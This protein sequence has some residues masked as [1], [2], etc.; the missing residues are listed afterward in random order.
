MLEKG[1]LQLHSKTVEDI[2]CVK[3]QKNKNIY[4]YFQNSDLFENT[5][6]T[7][8]YFHICFNHS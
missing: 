4:S 1:H 3:L 6:F 2:I 8:H 5:Y 7:K